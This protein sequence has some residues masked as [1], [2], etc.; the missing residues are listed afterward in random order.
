M[1]SFFILIIVLGTGIVSPV[2]WAQDKSAIEKETTDKASKKMTTKKK[3]EKENVIGNKTKRDPTTEKKIA[4]E[5]NDEIRGRK[6]NSEMPKITKSIEDVELTKGIKSTKKIESTKGIKSRE[7]T[8][9]TKKIKP[10]QESKSLQNPKPAQESKSLQ[11]P[12][13]AQESK[14]LQNP[15]PTQEST[16]L[17][18]PKPAQEST[19]LQNPKPP[20]E[21]TSLQ[22]PKPPQKPKPTQ[23]EKSPQGAKS[24]Q[25]L[26]AVA[27]TE[28]KPEKETKTTSNNIEYVL[29]ESV[30]QYLEPEKI[31]RTFNDTN[32][33]IYLVLH[34]N[35]QQTRSLYTVWRAVNVA[36][37]KAGEKVYG[38]SRL[39]E[40]GKRAAIWWKAPRQGFLPGEYEVAVKI[41]EAP[42]RFLKFK[43]KRSLQT[44]TLL[45]KIKRLPS[46]NIAHR[47]LGGMVVSPVASSK[48]WSA[49][50]LI[51]GKAWIKSYQMDDSCDSCGWSS[52]YRSTFPKDIILAFNQK[53]IATINAI[54][55][56]P[57]VWPAQASLQAIPQ[58]VELWVSETDANTGFR[59]ISSFRLQKKLLVQYWSFPA[60]KARY[61]KIKIYT[62][63]GFSHVK[64]G[65]IR[66][67]EAPGVKSVLVDFAKNIAHP[68]LGGHLVSFTSMNRYYPVTKLVDR[69][70][71]FLS[72]WVSGDSHKGDSSYLPQD[73][74]FAFRND[75]PAWV[76]RV[77]INTTAG[78]RYQSRENNRKSWPKKIALYGSYDDPF[79]EYQEIG[80]FD[81]AQ[82]SRD[83]VLLVKKKVRYL[84]VRVLENYGG[85]VTSL[86]EVR[87]IE[88][89]LPAY[90]SIVKHFLKIDKHQVQNMK[91]T[92]SSRPLLRQARSEQEPNNHFNN[93]LLA[94]TTQ[95]I[96]GQISPLT[97]IDLY[98]VK[99][100]G[101]T[102]K[103]FT[104]SLFTPGYIKT[105]IALLNANKKVIRQF[106]PSGFTGNKLLL[107]WLLKP[108]NYFL[109]LKTEPVSII[110][111]WDTSGSMSGRAA[112]LQKAID[113]FITRMGKDEQ[114]NLIRFSNHQVE[115][116]LPEF[117]NDK[118]KIRAAIR[119]KFFARGGT[120]LYDAINKA[121]SL[122]SPRKGNRAVI[123]LSDGGD[124]ESK[125]RYASILARVK[126]SKV[127]VYAI[128]LGTDLLTYNAR[129]LASGK[130][131]LAYIAKA[132]KG[133]AVFTPNSDQLGSIY[134]NIAHELV[135][136]PQY[137]VKA[138]V[139]QHPGKLQIVATGERIA[140]VASPEYVQ[141]I[142]DASGSMRRYTGKR[143]MISVARDIV[144][145]VVKGLP[146]DIKVAMRVY[147]EQIREG[148]HGAC[149][150]S[151]LLFG[152]GALG[153][154]QM[155]KKITQIRALG[156]TPIA[157]TLEQMA[158]DQKG[159]KQRRLAILVTDGKEE[160]GGDPVKVMQRLRIEDPRLRLNVVGFAID[161]E[162]VISGLKNLARAGQGR[163]F[164][165][166]NARQLSLMI[167][168]SL[169]VTFDVVDAS[170]LVVATGIV[171]KTSI[172]VPEGNYK[173]YVYPAGERIVLKNVLVNQKSLTRIELKKEGGIIGVNRLKPITLID[174]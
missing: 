121:I 142:L 53:R 11:N 28:I 25:K 127:P 144:R 119:N 156:T 4:R 149:E 97:E 54:A 7:K 114:V 23:N 18:N 72:G 1:R 75:K 161:D 64:L 93:K 46:Y 12:K 71:S 62:S 126:A 172:N 110:L 41:D 105:S 52:S 89:V 158:K 32:R 17:Q 125:I 137:Y 5:I 132:S 40:P 27:G 3:T 122:L 77:V 95:Y 61:V 74:I 50:N 128:G 31:T 87:I 109:K 153:R 118:Q 146:L 154:E 145:Q 14:S 162:H 90:Q 22:N 113:A 81:L 164:G 107:S 165:A 58:H 66:I 86:G 111:V 73:F 152:F 100:T 67:Y 155:L 38:W 24:E 59:K 79:G 166:D 20:Q 138:R 99:I 85:G 33:R 43:V 136:P 37:Y 70:L 55:I 117:T 173:I 51:D 131:V 135:K 21:S 35:A 171:G 160:C 80:R 167:R 133:R 47:A 78:Q 116:L 130:N 65:D 102:T 10:T 98:R 157:Y 36:G 88:G 148:R 26:N 84:K 6:K 103:A 112:D 45:S 82:E 48:Q 76:D 150:D 168:R 2:G 19:S 151:R 29:S 124:S 123:L 91:V 134:Q 56:D 96:R 141:L 69:T 147:G 104:L 143:R 15:K 34:S 159:I 106:D 169:A 57:R 44:A 174:R 120:P 101:R 42:I 13:P 39:L 63:Y 60:V 68:D 170:G 140:S 92:K 163:Y 108:G 16:S 83:H 9:S 8:K 129:S 49:A 115:V 139:S 30:N 94:L